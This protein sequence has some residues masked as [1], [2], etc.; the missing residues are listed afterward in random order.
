MLRR[1]C[2]D[3]LVHYVVDI[4]G[5][6]AFRTLCTLRGPGIRLYERM[7]ENAPL[8]CLQCAIFVASS[9]GASGAQ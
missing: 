8:T 1:L 4:A 2:E 7:S 5:L 6:G 9:H 3:G